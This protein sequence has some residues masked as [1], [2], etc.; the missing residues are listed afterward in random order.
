MSLILIGFSL[1]SFENAKYKNWFQMADKPKINTRQTARKFKPV[2]FNR[3]ALGT[4]SIAL[5]EIIN[6]K[7]TNHV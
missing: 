4:S 5:M 3:E 1:K 2:R 6:D 7:L